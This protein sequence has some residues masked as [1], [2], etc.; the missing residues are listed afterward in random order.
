V[1]VVAEGFKIVTEIVLHDSATSSL[2]KITSGFQRVS[3]EADTALQSISGF[4]TRL[5]MQFTGFSGG[6]FGFLKSAVD[7]SNEFEKLQLGFANVLASNKEFF[8]GAETFA[9]RMLVGKAA[10]DAIVLESRKFGLSANELG[11][12]SKGTAQILAPMGLSGTNFNVSTDLS[13]NFLKVIRTLPGLESGQA[14]GQFVDLLTGN[15]GD[16]GRFS[17]LLFKDAIATFS[18]DEYG[19]KNAKDY[20]S[21]FKSDPAKA[22]KALSE[23]MSGLTRHEDELNGFIGLFSSKMTVLKDLFFGFS[24]VLKPVGDALVKPLKQVLDFVINFVQND[25][26]NVMKRLGNILNVFLDDPKD[27]IARLIEMKDLGS[28]AG[29][30]ASL[31]GFMQLISFF[32][33]M[34]KVKSVPALAKIS[35]FIHN[36]INVPMDFTTKSA[37][38]ISIVKVMGRSL[39]L[40]SVFLI[41][42]QAF[43][44]AV[45][46][47]KVSDAMGR[48][49]N[50]VDFWEDLIKVTKRLL[51]PIDMVVDGLSHIMYILMRLAFTTFNYGSVS[52]KVGM[53]FIGM[54]EFFSRGI[55]YYMAALKGFIQFYLS[56]FDQLTLGIKTW[57][58]GIVQFIAGL[59]LDDLSSPGKTLSKFGNAIDPRVAFA[60][61]FNAIGTDVSQIFRETLKNNLIS[62]GTDEDGAPNAKNEVNI[63]TFQLNQQFREQ[64][65][66]DR[67]AFTVKEQMLKTAN[68]AR[69]QGKRTM[70]S[71]L[72][73]YSVAGA[74]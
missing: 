61:M 7:A 64:Q 14:Q 30:A 59:S 47:M 2:D 58:T 35:G 18:K 3:D 20:N 38:L 48:F 49:G 17:Q 19:I 25:F 10:M 66:P 21:V 56:V 52:E 22:L 74:Q 44:R 13:A 8:T 34:E 62:T 53:N 72:N 50:L 45:A 26:A 67:I 69:T 46:R 54:I 41:L 9:E 37:G 4:G 70:M 63:G 57:I 11:E 43:S 36:L 32:A 27:L 51:A 16:Q 15:A 12:F 31:V 24:S 1:A 6:I 68:N 65:N 73:S 5:A 23:A 29:G 71:G 39:G 60:G 42:F 33:T 40:F 55:I 28:N